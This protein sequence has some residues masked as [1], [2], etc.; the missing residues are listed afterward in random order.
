M[1]LLQQ[2]TN[3]MSEGKWG[4]MKHPFICKEVCISKHVL[5]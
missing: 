5:S 4:R 2:R 1:S 3:S